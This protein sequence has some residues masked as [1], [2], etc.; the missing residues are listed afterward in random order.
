MPFS[1]C[2]GEKGKGRDEVRENQVVADNCV[3]MEKCKEA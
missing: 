3:F 2:P 1:R